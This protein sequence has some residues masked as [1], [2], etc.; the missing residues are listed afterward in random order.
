MKTMK[1]QYFSFDAIIATLI[2]ILTMVSVF[3]YW[4]NTRTALDTQNSDLMREAQRISDVL[5][6]AP[7]GTDTCHV[8]M[9]F[10][11]S[12]NSVSEQ[13]VYRT[14]DSSLFATNS[15][16]CTEDKLKTGFGTP[17]NVYMEI[18]AASSGEH[19]TPSKPA[20]SAFRA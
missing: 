12:V 19:T 17:Y 2:F 14:L 8:S 11:Q 5:F 13:Q 20:F 18:K 3:S 4:S 16:E 7:S 10:V 1:G 6:M 9:G 15:V